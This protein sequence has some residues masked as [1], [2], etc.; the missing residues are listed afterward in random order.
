MRTTLPHA[1]RRPASSGS[2]CGGRLAGSALLLLFTLLTAGVPHRVYAQEI[3][4][5]G[6][7]YSGRSYGSE[8]LFNPVSAILNAGYDLIQL[9]HVDRQVGRYPY[10]HGLRNVWRSVAHPVRA[11]REYGLGDFV[12]NELFPLSTR[13]SDGGQWVPNYQLHLIG[14]G[15]MYAGL[16]EWYAY[17]DFPAPRTLAV[18]TATAYHVLTETVENGGHAGYNVDAVADF[19]VFDVAGILI[20]SSPKVQRFFAETLHLAS[21][22]LQPSFAMEPLTLQNNGQY[23]AMRWQLPFAD[24]WQLF[25]YF[26]MNNLLGTS[27]RLQN[28]DGVTFGAGLHAKELVTVDP[29][30]NKKT[31]ELVGTAGLFYDRQNSLLA[32][33][34]YSGLHE[35]MLVANVYPG[36][37]RIGRFSPGVWAQVSRDGSVLA[38][39]STTWTPGLSV[40][41]TR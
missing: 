33:L 11:V 1:A 31:A 12:T 29:N 30:T 20:F 10:R 7:F 36:L 25:Y 34:V 41:V 40:R 15:M 18:A 27:Y 4:E 28:G 38:G 2:G 9:D 21:W 17:H 14:G 8:A 37:L 23:F 6:Y 19:Y 39:I 5:P 24:R 16:A 26:G 13:A 35:S 22:S 32:S 3:T